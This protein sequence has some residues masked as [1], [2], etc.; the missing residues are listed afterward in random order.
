MVEVLRAEVVKLSE[1]LTVLENR[2]D[3]EKRR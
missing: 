2:L 3:A 1:R